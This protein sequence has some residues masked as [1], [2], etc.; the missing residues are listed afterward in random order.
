MRSLSLVPG[1]QR[2]F[3]WPTWSI[4]EMTAIPT[5]SAD[6]KMMRLRPIQ[7]PQYS[8]GLSPPARMAIPTNSA[9]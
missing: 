4:A 5:I 7:L 2:A 6:P 1:S 8:S 3:C 9:K